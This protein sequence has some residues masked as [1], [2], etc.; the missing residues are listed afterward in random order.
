MV[1]QYSKGIDSETASREANR[2]RALN[3]R[4]GRKHESGT[5]SPEFVKTSS[6]DL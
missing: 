5:E 1:M 6:H 2:R 3:E 4:R